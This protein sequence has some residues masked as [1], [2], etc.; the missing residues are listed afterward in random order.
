MVKKLEH[1]GLHILVFVEDPGALNGIVPIANQLVL[2]GHKVSIHLEGYAKAAVDLN[3][4]GLRVVSDPFEGLRKGVYSLLLTGTSENLKS[5]A[6]ELVNCC[7]SLGIKSFGFID[8]PANSDHRFS[9]G[10]NQ[11]LLYAPDYLI[12]VDEPTAKVFCEFG[13]RDERVVVIDHP[14]VAEVHRKWAAL[15]IKPIEDMKETIFRKEFRNEKVVVFC[16]E[17]SSGLQ[18]DGME[19]NKEYSLKAP[20]NILKRTDVVV[21]NFLAAVKQLKTLGLSFKT[22]IRLHPK[23]SE[24][25]ILQINDFDYVSK[26]GESVE[27]CLAS[28]IVVGM[29]SMV[30]AEAHEMGKPVVSLLPRLKEVDWMPVAIRDKIKIC[31][32][33]E[34]LISALYEIFVAD[35]REQPIST[36]EVNDSKNGSLLELIESVI[37]SSEEAQLS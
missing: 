20:D 2:R 16:S 3:L 35:T 18:Q 15:S 28:D 12:V 4:P 17:L 11:P 14:R 9:G 13:L 19:R 10:S 32:S 23:Q 5:R 24:N 6:F 7:K 25:D 21:F 36:P 1:F 34:D 22:V 8:S 33:K 26:G 30:L 27:V 31:Y 37:M 29:G